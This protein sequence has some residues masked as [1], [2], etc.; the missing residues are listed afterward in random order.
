MFLMGSRLEMTYAKPQRRVEY[1]AEGS[2]EFAVQTSEITAVLKIVEGNVGLFSFANEI[3]GRFGATRG[4]DEGLSHKLSPFQDLCDL[5]QV[6]KGD[7]FGLLDWGCLDRRAAS[8]ILYG[9]L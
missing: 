1:L 2:R 7:N 8:R 9:G 4:A 5:G 3:V 6:G